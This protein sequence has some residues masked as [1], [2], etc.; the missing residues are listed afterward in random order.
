VSTKPIMS[1]A[2]VDSVL[3]LCEQTFNFGEFEHSS[4]LRIANF[5]K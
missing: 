5:D 3:F 4:H 1:R 2:L